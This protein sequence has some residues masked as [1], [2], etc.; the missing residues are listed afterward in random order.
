M[1]CLFAAFFFCFV[2][3]TS[4]APVM[5]PEMMLKNQ[6]GRVLARLEIEA[7]QVVIERVHDHAK[8]DFTLYFRSSSS[9]AGEGEF[10]MPLPP[11]AVVTGHALDVNGVMRDAVA[12]PRGKANFAYETVRAPNHEPG[13]DEREE[14]N[15][16]RVE[17]FPVLPKGV[18]VVRLTWLQAME[19]CA[20]DLHLNLPFDFRVRVG[21]FEATL[22]PG[23]G[24]K[25]FDCGGLEFKEMPSGGWKAER[26]DHRMEKAWEIVFPSLMLPSV[27]IEQ[28]GDRHFHLVDHAPSP[29]SPPSPTRVAVVWDVSS[30]R[31][32]VDIGKDLAVIDSLAHALPRAKWEAVILRDTATR[33]SGDAATIRKRLEE[34]ARDGWTDWSK[35][36]ALGTD[37]TVVFTDLSPVSR[38]QILPDLP[39]MVVVTHAPPPRS[40]HGIPRGVP[41]YSHAE[42]APDRMAA[43][44]LVPR[45]TVELVTPNPCPEIEVP[46]IIQ[47]GQRVIIT[48]R[49]MGDTT[50]WSLRYKLA[51]RVI[52]ERPVM[53]DSTFAPFSPM[54]KNPLSTL[55]ALAVQTRLEDMPV[56]DDE[57]LLKHEMENGLVGELTSRIVPETLDHYVQYRIPPPEPGMLAR[58]EEEIR[59]KSEFKVSPA[60]AFFKEWSPRAYWRAQDWPWLDQKLQPRLKHHTIW[61][62]AIRRTFEPGQ[63]N[64]DFLKASEA[65]KDKAVKLLAE[66]G[67]YTT[68]AQLSAWAERIDLHAQAGHAL[69]NTETPAPPPGT[70]VA[71]SVQGLVPR[72]GVF[73]IEAPANLWVAMVK[74]GFQRSRGHHENVVLYRNGTKRWIYRD[75]YAATILRPGDMIVVD[76]TGPTPKMV[77]IDPF[78]A[79]PGGINPF[80]SDP[81]GGATASPKAEKPPAD[82]QWIRAVVADDSPGP[83]AI[84]KAVAGKMDSYA[85][86]LRLA[87]GKRHGTEFY[88]EA[89]RVLASMG[90]MDAAVRVLGN[91]RELP[92]NPFVREREFAH[93]LW[94]I[95]GRE[96]AEALLATLGN[97]PEEMALVLLDRAH[98][99]IAADKPDHA[100]PHLFALAEDEKYPAALRASALAVLN[101]LP[102]PE[103]AAAPAIHQKNRSYIERMD[104]DIRMVLI[105]PDSSS[106]ARLGVEEPFHPPEICRDSSRVGGRIF[107]GHGISEYQIARALPG[108]YRALVWNS[109]SSI[110]TIFLFTNWGKANQTCQVHFVSLGESVQDQEIGKLRFELPMGP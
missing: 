107:S 58:Y 61:A 52:T 89:A 65:W 50:G 17:G 12:M 2:T 67:E 13:C 25:S 51:D 94:M 87:D 27:A 83:D 63:Y 79:S 41:V 81:F 49:A 71:V 68:P 90:Q 110:A 42:F 75:E 76:L 80:A 105:H 37:L 73:V 8:V 72:K 26:S 14:G 11:G 15:F 18:R 7:S 38:P 95:G 60:N 55:H 74:A 39:G 96:A 70:P 69:E 35:V 10:I 23:S 101:S 4:A 21:K 32:D 33:I 106:T 53:K 44:I 104:S 48:G 98:F 62:D 54:A 1:N 19:Q 45:L 40:N 109:Q 57:A 29:V 77:D 3:V 108:Q 88:V 56:R 36:P 100:R 99:L 6:F 82:A 24:A 92:G 46:E 20:E 47:A 103:G 66:E 34:T 31:L 28:G 9:E 16:Y 91:L 93:I 97:A 84:K 78:A 43:R 85:A 86:Y 22:L 102:R 30:S 59:R 5:G 64:A